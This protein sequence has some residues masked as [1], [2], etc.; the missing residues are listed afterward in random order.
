MEIKPDK[1][2]LLS[3]IYGELSEEEKRRVE[4]WF[5]LHP[6]DKEELLSL[7]GT[8]KILSHLPDKSVIVPKIKFPSPVSFWQHPAFRLPV[9]IAAGLAVLILAAKFA[10]TEMELNERGFRMG[11][12]KSAPGNFPNLQHLIDSSVAKSREEISNELKAQL[13]PQPA[14]VTKVSMPAALSKE[15]VRRLVISLQA[16]Q[17]D[18]LKNYLQNA[19]ARQKKYLQN[20]VVDFAKYSALQ[21]QNYSALEAKFDEMQTGNKRFKNETQQILTGII[22][23]ME[24]QPLTKNTSY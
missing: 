1:N 14:A 9:G 16:E 18:R 6:A 21:E 7:Q 4:E 17:T 24:G 13:T 19:E 15:E 23:G 10:G 8:K 5:V 12:Q 22:S 20:L 3:Y 11:F 2:T